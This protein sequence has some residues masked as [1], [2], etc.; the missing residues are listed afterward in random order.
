[1]FGA[2]DLSVTD[3]RKRAGH[4]QAT[5]IAVTLFADWRRRWDTL[6]WI[7]PVRPRSISN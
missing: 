2:M 5:Q 7:M 4:K 3:D 1:M 6:S